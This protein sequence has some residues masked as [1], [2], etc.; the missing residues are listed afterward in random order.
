MIVALGVLLTAAA[1][2]LL[3]ARLGDDDGAGDSGGP[4]PITDVPPPVTDATDEP[5]TTADDTTTTT[6]PHETIDGLEVVDSGFSTYE[7][8]DGQVGSYGLVLENTT[9]QPI[10]NFTVEIVIYDT[11]DTVI[12]SDPHAVAVVNPGAR[13]GLGAEVAGP[14]PNGIG[15]LDIQVEEGTGGPVPQGAF[16]I[17][18]VSTSSDEF[19]IYTAFVVSSTYE[20]E[21]ELPYAYAVYRNAAGRIVGGANG[22]VDVIPARGRANGEVT[23]FEVVPHVAQAEVYVDPGFF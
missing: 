13:L 2:G 3:V 20:V 21:L 23:S 11:T 6:A 4:S 17:T 16:T 10:T 14:L 19:G 5:T 15:R 12:S 1:I 8:F 9:D 18:D 7:G 22:F